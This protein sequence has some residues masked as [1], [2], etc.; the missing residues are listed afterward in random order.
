M[1]P[2][3]SSRAYSTRSQKNICG[4]SE[5]FLLHA[6]QAAVWSSLYTSFTYCSTAETS[7]LKQ[8]SVGQLGSTY[9]NEEAVHSLC[10]PS[11]FP[12]R[13]FP[14]PFLCWDSAGFEGDRSVTG[15]FCLHTQALS[16]R[17][18]WAHLFRYGDSKNRE[19][20]WRQWM[21][22]VPILLVTVK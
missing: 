6:C 9:S 15:P 22:S 5:K 10:P 8:Y 2:L 20:F 1:K 12:L 17:G 21:G 16:T 7:E 14:G 11:S 13:D 18:A 4:F 3:F 19:V